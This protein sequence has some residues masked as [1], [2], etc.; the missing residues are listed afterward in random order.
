MF[1]PI[2]LKTYHLADDRT[3]IQLEVKQ[4]VT[5]ICNHSGQGKTLLASKIRAIQERALVSNI[6]PDIL[7][8]D[9]I[10]LLKA[11]S[12]SDCSLVIIDKMEQY[13]FNQ[14]V[15]HCIEA[16]PDKYF[17]V[18]LRG[19]YDLPFGPHSLAELVITRNADTL[20]FTL[21]Y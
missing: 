17:I 3:N 2:V 20:S 10:D 5:L 9:S 19:P 14:Q 13:A 16:N 7:I 8:V 21:E 4:Y 1:K 11:V 12:T 18:F 6:T 15:E